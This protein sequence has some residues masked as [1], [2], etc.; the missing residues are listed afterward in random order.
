MLNFSK[1][2]TAS[3]LEIDDKVLLRNFKNKS[4][5]DPI[6]LPEDYKVI[7]ISDEG[8]YFLI[9]RQ[10]DKKQFKHHPDDVKKFNP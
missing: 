4:K 1:Y 7:N 10:S 2:S 6:F 9:E 3:S 5:F 8:R